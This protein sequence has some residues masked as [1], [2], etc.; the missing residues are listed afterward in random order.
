MLIFVFWMYNA[1]P[2]GN[3]MN[4]PSLISDLESNIEVNTFVLKYSD[5]FLS[6]QHH[7]CV[8]LNRDSKEIFAFLFRSSCSDLIFLDKE[9]PMCLL[10]SLKT[11]TQ[12]CLNQLHHFMPTI[13]LNFWVLVGQKGEYSCTHD[14]ST[15]ITMITEND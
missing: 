11:K 13:N 2:L 3:C 15:P 10:F 8:Y 1:L 14:K 12:F 7:K 4:L 9:N 6:V 5:Q